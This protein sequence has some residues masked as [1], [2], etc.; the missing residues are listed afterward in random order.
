MDW[1]DAERQVAEAN[2][3]AKTWNLPP[4]FVP[5]EDD[6]GKIIGWKVDP[7]YQKV[8]EY[9]PQLRKRFLGE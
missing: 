6:A 3:T 8:L 7:R 2:Q 4:V 1:K 5:M 9:S